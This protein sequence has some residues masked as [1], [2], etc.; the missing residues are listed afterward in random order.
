[1]GAHGEEDPA[2]ALQRQLDKAREDLGYARDRASSAEAD[3]S[4]VLEMLA[5][6]EKLLPVIPDSD[7]GQRLRLTIVNLLK[8]LRKQV[9]TRW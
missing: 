9:G 3:M 6:A 1:M 4:N 2:E 8:I 7:A 5:D